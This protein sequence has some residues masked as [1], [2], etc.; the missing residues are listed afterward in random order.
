MELLELN[1]N[2]VGRETQIFDH[3]IKTSKEFEQQFDSLRL[4]TPLIIKSNLM[5]SKAK[6]VE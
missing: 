5:G 6:T 4:P 1:L 2:C 3:F